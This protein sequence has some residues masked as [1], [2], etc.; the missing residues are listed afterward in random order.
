[1]RTDTLPLADMQ[2][3]AQVVAQ[4]SFAGAARQ[5]RLT[6]GAVS[7]SVGRLE[8]ELGVKLLH[9]TTRSLSLTEVGAAVHADC[10]LMLQSAEQAVSRAT[11]HRQQPQG[12]LRINA[13]LVFGDWWLAPLL[14]GFCARFPEVQVQLSMSD[15]MA[16]LTAEGLD[17][18]IRIT[19]ADALPPAMVARPLQPVGYVLVAS[20]AYL[21]SRPPITQPQDLLAHPCMS[22]G[23]GPFQNLVELLPADAPTATVTR[24][25]LNTPITIASSQGLLNAL[26]HGAASGIALMADFVARAHLADGR[27]VQ[28]LPNWQLAGSYAPRMAY[29]LHAPG[30]HIPPKLRVMLDYLQSQNASASA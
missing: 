18:A 19:A 14:P 30:P 28:V 2:V 22:L 9:R 3:F 6:T 27:L 17:L 16:D 5:L 13:P 11:V 20:P 25:R 26:Q 23:Y 12:I 29:A 24:L 21:Q 1:M 7:R 4:H 15:A 10:V 8:S